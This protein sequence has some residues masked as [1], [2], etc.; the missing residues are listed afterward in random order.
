MGK[1]SHP[2]R[3]AAFGLTT[4]AVAVAAAGCGGSSTSAATVSPERWQTSVC[5]A[6]TT[7]ARAAE[8]DH[9]ELEGLSLEF[10]F[11]LPK[12]SDVRRTEAVATAALGDD[13]ARLRQ[14][15]EAAGIPRFEHGAEFRAEL[16]A[17]LHELED[18]L[19]ALHS[20]ALD[21]P[22]GADRA[23]ADSL[24]TPKVDAAIDRVS[25]RMRTA[26]ARY[27]EADKIG[28]P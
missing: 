5:S 2:V 17:A 15:V 4:V 22:T 11:G 26:H 28:C 6:L 8:H 16:V 9:R 14:A 1:I 21:L 24:L 25:Q 10:K 3:C 13:T 18:R 19:D 27:P 23:P 20:E 7:Y 12:S